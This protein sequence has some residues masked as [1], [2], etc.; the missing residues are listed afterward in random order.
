MEWSEFHW[1]RDQA[2]LMHKEILIPMHRYSC[3]VM[4]F[5]AVERELGRLTT[6][7]NKQIQQKLKVKDLKGSCID[8]TK[9]HLT[10]RQNLPCTLQKGV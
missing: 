2:D 1:E 4:L 5:V 10:N 8:Q 9:S 6:N 7:L 3:I